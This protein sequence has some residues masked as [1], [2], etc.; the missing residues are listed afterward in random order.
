METLQALQVGIKNGVD[1][2]ANNLAIPQ[3][4]EHKLSI[5]SSN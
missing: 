3:N 5:V 2:L 1:S 4:T